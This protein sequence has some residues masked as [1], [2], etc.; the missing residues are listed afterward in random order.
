MAYTGLTIETT[1]HDP[2]LSSHTIPAYPEYYSDTTF[3]A[4]FYSERRAECDRLVGAAVDYQD[5]P[6]QG[7]GAGGGAVDLTGI[8]LDG[9]ASIDN[10]GAKFVFSFTGTGEDE[11]INDYSVLWSVPAGEG[12]LWGYASDSSDMQYVQVYGKQ[13]GGA[14]GTVT[15]TFVERGNSANTV[16]KTKAFT[17]N[18]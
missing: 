4:A 10:D 16:V 9:P 8:T 5:D 17:F 3:D 7:P 11:V 12:T 15:C 13:A 14:G 18:P 6:N 2:T 1:V